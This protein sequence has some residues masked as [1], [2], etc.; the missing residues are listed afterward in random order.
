MHQLYKSLLHNTDSERHSYY[1]PIFVQFSGFQSLSNPPLQP[2]T[3]IG[4]TGEL[5]VASELMLLP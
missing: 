5:R 1:L 3:S 2:L 4:M